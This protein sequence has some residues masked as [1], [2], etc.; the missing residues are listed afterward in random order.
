[1]AGPL[2]GMRGSGRLSCLRAL[3]VGGGN[4]AAE[5]ALLVRQAR[6]AVGQRTVRA[7]R[8]VRLAVA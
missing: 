6:G 4:G 3:V 1:M 7:G 2:R 5:L 8:V